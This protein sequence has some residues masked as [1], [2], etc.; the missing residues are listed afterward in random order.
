MRAELADKSLMTDEL[1]NHKSPIRET[2][3]E[4]RQLGR[5]LLA[6]AAFGSL[7]TVEPDTGFPHISRIAFALDE[8]GQP[9]SLMSTLA[10]H[11]KALLQNPQ[12]SVLLG[13]PGKGD[14]LAH[15]RI[16][17]QAQASQILHKT[18]EHKTVRARYLE[19]HTKA[20]LYVDFGDFFFFR[21]RVQKAYLNGGFG[22]A[23]ILTAEDLGFV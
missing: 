23:F 22:K 13:E 4:A 17:L 16:S 5:S 12:C 19:Q 7:A 15:P 9:V 2:S 1:K 3:E 10:F 11:T 8:N 6:D 18:D 21:F 14:P 20:A